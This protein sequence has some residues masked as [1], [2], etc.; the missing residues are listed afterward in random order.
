[1]FRCFKNRVNKLIDERDALTFKRQKISDKKNLVN[2]Q[3]ENKIRKLEN[4][5]WRNQ[6]TAT[7]QIE[8]INRQ[9]ERVERNLNSEKEYVNGIST[10][11]NEEIHQSVRD[12]FQGCLPTEVVQGR[13]KKAKEDK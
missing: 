9:L 2:S 1:M 7:N 8:E 3:I 13:S 6:I 4:E 5:S 12:S 11:K 10:Y